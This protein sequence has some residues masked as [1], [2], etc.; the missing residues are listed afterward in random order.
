M[1]KKNKK[2]INY[3]ISRK[4]KAFKALE[5]RTMMNGRMDRYKKRKKNIVKHQN[6]RKKLKINIFIYIYIKRIR[7]GLKRS[8][9]L[10]YFRYSYLIS[11]NKGGKF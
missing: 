9:L 10:R 2:P 8:Y 4:I 6:C 3:I 5:N 7:Q 11:K 1:K